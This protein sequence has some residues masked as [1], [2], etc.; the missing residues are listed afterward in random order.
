MSLSSLVHG[1]CLG[2]PCCDSLGDGS[3]EVF[4]QK[5]WR[6]WT[7]FAFTVRM[8]CCCFTDL[9]PVD[10]A[11]S[12]CLQGKYSLSEATIFKAQ[13]KL[14]VSLL[15]RNGNYLRNFL[16]ISQ[17]NSSLYFLFFYKSTSW[18]FKCKKYYFIN[19]NNYDNIFFPYLLLS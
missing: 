6:T 16:K 8:I 7:A 5:W 11:P 12:I 2:W 17:A 3:L 1:R 4:V 14:F 15:P 9:H 18:Y 19:I 13:F 10:G